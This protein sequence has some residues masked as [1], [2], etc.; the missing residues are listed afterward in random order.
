MRMIK[1]DLLKN[2]P[3]AVP[4]IANIWYDVL[5]KIWMPEIE[6]KE[7]EAL[8]YEE[9]NQEMPITYIALH[10]AAGIPVGACTLELNGGI[11][12]DLTPWIGDLVVDTKYQKQGIGK[13]LL[14][15]AVRKAHELGFQ[16]IYLFTFDA[17]IASYYIRFGW[18]QIGLDIFKSK[19]V[20]LMEKCILITSMP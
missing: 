11:R 19:P 3:H 10:G 7:I 6:I 14:D 18:E 9:L 12:P 16:K 17:S 4:A 8:S 13:I 1:I 15:T 5:G 20:I 2:N